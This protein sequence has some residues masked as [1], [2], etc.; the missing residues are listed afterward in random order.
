MIHE[1]HQWKLVEDFVNN[2]NEYHTQIFSPL[3]LICA[4][5]SILWWYG[6]G[7]HWINLGLPRYVAIDK[8]LENGAD[9]QNY[10]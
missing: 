6:Q 3:D 1:A 7:D 10:A 2:F 5:E 8:K 4:D 9:I